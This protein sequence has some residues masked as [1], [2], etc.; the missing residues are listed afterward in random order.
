[1]HAPSWQREQQEAFGSRLQVCGLWSVAQFCLAQK[2]ASGDEVASS[3]NHLFEKAL[4]KDRKWMEIVVVRRATEEFY[5]F[6][7]WRDGSAVQC[8]LFYQRT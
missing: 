6:C 2:T 1:M 5:C 7:G 4:K 8:L 3:A